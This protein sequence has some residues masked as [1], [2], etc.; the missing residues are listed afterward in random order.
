MAYTN[1]NTNTGE[2][3]E[4]V[5]YKLDSLIEII[6]S[7]ETTGTG[8]FSISPELLRT[9]YA[10]MEQPAGTDIGSGIFEYYPAMFDTLMCYNMDVSKEINVLDQVPVFRKEYIDHLT[11]GK[12]VDVYGY[13]GGGY[14]TY[15]VTKDGV[16]ISCDKFITTGTAGEEIPVSFAGVSLGVSSLEVNDGVAASATDAS[17]P[18][19]TV[20][21]TVDNLE[22]YISTPS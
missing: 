22:Q 4:L 3:T 10:V 11:G 21:V 7:L 8:E 5:K 2:Q 9:Y 12:T 17:F 1:P 14:Y 15:S 19:E 6:G 20:T 16:T 13:I 18:A